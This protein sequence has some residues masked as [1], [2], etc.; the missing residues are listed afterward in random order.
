LYNDKS[1]LCLKGWKRR[2]RYDYNSHEEKQRNN[3]TS[4]TTKVTILKITISTVIVTAIIAIAAIITTMI[5]IIVEAKMMF[6]AVAG[7]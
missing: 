2:I 7:T 1:R 6:R 5:V 3:K 4:I